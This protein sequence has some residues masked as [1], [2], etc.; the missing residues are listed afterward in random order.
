VNNSPAPFFL[1]GSAAMEKRQIIRRYAPEQ[2]DGGMIH[3]GGGM[4]IPAAMQ[5]MAIGAQL[6]ANQNEVVRQ[7]VEL[8]DDEHPSVTFRET[9][10]IYVRD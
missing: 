8:I 9:I 7:C 1:K 5:A 6:L 10:T 4:M 2:M 3:G